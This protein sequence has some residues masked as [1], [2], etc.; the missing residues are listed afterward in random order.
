MFASSCSKKVRNNAAFTE[1]L[2]LLNFG[3]QQIFCSVTQNARRRTLRLYVSVRSSSVR[4]ARPSPSSRNQCEPMR[5]SET[6]ANHYHTINRSHKEPTAPPATCETL[7]TRLTWSST[8]LLA[9]DQ[10]INPLDQLSFEG[11]CWR[12]AHHAISRV[13]LSWPTV[14]HPLAAQAKTSLHDKP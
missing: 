2:N 3:L 14:P 13:A 11:A 1:F 4:L 5:T 6:N 9:Q 12:M 8:Y 7:R 10:C